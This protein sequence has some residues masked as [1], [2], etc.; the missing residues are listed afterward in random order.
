MNRMMNNYNESLYAKHIT[1]LNL[2]N[3]IARIQRY[4][5]AMVSKAL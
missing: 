1:L 4:L 2:T 3:W 5:K